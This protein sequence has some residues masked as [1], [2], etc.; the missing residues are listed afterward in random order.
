MNFGT[1]SQL[2]VLITAALAVEDKPNIVLVLVDDWG[3]ANVGYH[4]D[5]QTPEVDTPNINSLVQQGLELDHHYASSTC[6]PSRCS[7]L[8][9]RLPIHVND[10]NRNMALYNPDDPIAGYMG[11]PVGMTTLG[12]KM[13]EGGYATHVVGKWN[14]GTATYEHTPEGRG[15][16][17][18][19]IYFSS[20]NDYY[21]QQVGECDGTPIVD[22]WDSGKPARE[23]NGTGYEEDIFKE[24]ILKIVEDHPTSSPLFLYYAP[25]IM[26]T[27]LD[28]PD[29]YLTQFDFIDDD[30]RQPYMAMVKY[31]DDVIGEL[32]DALKD[33]DMWSNTLLVISSDN[34][35]QIYAGNNYPLKGLKGSDWQGGVRVNAFVSGGYLPDSMQGMK[36]DEYIHLADWYATFS[37]L[38]GVDP[39]DEAAALAGLPAI[40]SLDMW[41]LIS[42]QVSTSP[43]TDVPISYNT[44]ISG[45][46]K[47]LTGTVPNAG[48]TE[49]V[50]PNSNSGRLPDQECGN[51]GCLYDIKNDPEEL[52]DLASTRRPILREMRT[53]LQ[54]YQ[55]TLFDPDR[56]SVSS[57][58]CVAAQGVYKGFWGPFVDL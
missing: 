56:G 46:Y 2:I 10:K 58:A 48:W 18:S 24:R 32:V 47:I 42:G 31:F 53:K 7:L 40:D 21:T 49:E 19:L 22:L 15:F 23:L 1:L 29:S 3:W 33:K 26:H 6:S 5:P 12:T 9:G 35:G 27:P 11:I 39:T 34:G 44:L 30:N 50:Y 17:S 20:S 51:K 52:Y 57:E 43:R 16:D 55:G 28:V 38:A 37:N 14:V 13:K 54:S 41:P 8:S 25:H 36:T 4:R 45:D